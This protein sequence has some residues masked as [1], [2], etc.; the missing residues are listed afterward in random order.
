MQP[1]TPDRCL[2][3]CCTASS[4]SLQGRLASFG[5]Q[6]TQGSIDELLLASDDEADHGEAAQAKEQPQAASKG[7]TPEAAAAQ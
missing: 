3:A 5:A 2:P 6:L 7:S 4:C 1:S